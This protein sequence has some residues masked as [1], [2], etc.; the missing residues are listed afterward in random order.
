[1][2]IL[3]KPIKVKFLLKFKLYI[4]KNILNK[5]VINIQHKKVYLLY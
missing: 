4:H 1:M 3:E 5:F 2:K